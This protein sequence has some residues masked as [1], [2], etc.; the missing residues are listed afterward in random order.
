MPP[1]PPKATTLPPTP[2]PKVYAPQEAMAPPPVRSHDPY[3]GPPVG[4]LPAL[5][6]QLD[7]HHMTLY[8]G[9][10]AGFIA[11]KAKNPPHH[12]AKATAKPKAKDLAKPKGT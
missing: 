9:I 3:Y 8:Q 7:H 10:V 1:C 6:A 2:M 5:L 11:P 4:G 12:K